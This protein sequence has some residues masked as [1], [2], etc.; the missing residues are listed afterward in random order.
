VVLTVAW[1]ISL[2]DGSRYRAQGDNPA[3]A[4]TELM[5]A[6]PVSLPPGR[7]PPQDAETAGELAGGVAVSAARLR[8]IAQAS[9][10]Q[11]AWS[12]VLTGESW[13]WAATGAAVICY[14]SELM[15]R[16]LAESPRVA[17]DTT[18]SGILDAAA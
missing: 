2:L 1:V 12:T 8:I 3:A 17:A 16:S 5:R 15:L 14:L 10:E 13:Q 11:A 4:D 9:G 6:I 7:Q 18:L